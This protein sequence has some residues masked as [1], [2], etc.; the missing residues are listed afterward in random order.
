MPLDPQA[1]RGFGSG[2]DEYERHRP[3]WPPEAVER[4]LAELGVGVDSTVVDL[5][6]GTGKLARVL[7]P[8]VGRVVAVEPS[9]DMRRRL[10]AV[11]P[12]VEALDG[13]ADSMPLGDASADALFAAEAFHWFA[14]REAAA[15]IARVVRPGG[16]VALLWNLYD[17]GDDAWVEDVGAALGP[18]L[19]ET[20]LDSVGRHEPEKW[21]GAFE[22]APFGPFE[23][24]DVRNEHRT[25]ASGLIAHISTWS[26]VRALDDDARAA[27]EA[28]L[29]GVVRRADWSPDEVVLRFQTAVYW[30]RRL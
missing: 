3:G 2:A 29:E 1:E 16:G 7:L 4:A 18:H 21:G 20:A 10:G 13:T 19:P 12:Q 26:F 14:T 22:A 5:A 9:R 8:R 25:D 28:E 15:E 11:V 30:A 6:A 24:F 27:L 23:R 17:W